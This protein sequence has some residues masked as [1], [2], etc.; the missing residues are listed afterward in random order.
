MA[1]FREIS[2][3]SVQALYD[4]SFTVYVPIHVIPLRISFTAVRSL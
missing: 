1:S 2:G 4:V 3:F